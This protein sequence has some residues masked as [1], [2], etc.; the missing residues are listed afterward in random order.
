MERARFVIDASGRGTLL[1]SGFRLE[2]KDPTFAE[3]SLRVRLSRLI[4]LLS[5]SGS[6]P[7][8]FCLGLARYSRGGGVGEDGGG[9]GASHGRASQDMIL[10]ALLLLDAGHVLSSGASF[11]VEALG[12]F[13]RPAA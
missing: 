5:E 10:G 8:G 12:H 13:L 11:H 9:G 3:P 6:V 1:G 4:S 7:R 2:K